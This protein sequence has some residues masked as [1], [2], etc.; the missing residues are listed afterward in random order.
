MTFDCWKAQY[1]RLL[2]VLVLAGLSVARATPEE[3]KGPLKVPLDVAVDRFDVAD[4][5][6][7]DG[8]S[9]LSLKRIDGL[10]LGFEE[11]L[12]NDV[13]QDPRATNPH[14]SLH[15][16]GQTVR[17]IL[18]SLCKI[19]PRYEWSQDGLTINVYP[20]TTTEDRL[21]L[22]NLSIDRLSVTSVSD[23]Y[24]AL[25]PLA[26]LFPDQQIGYAGTG[27]YSGYAEPWTT[28]FERLTVRQFI[29]RILEHVGPRTTWVWQG[30]KNERMF[31]FLKDGFN[32]MRPAERK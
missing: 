16:R 3:G 23:A 21:Y 11:V 4:A 13:R 31:A 2:G 28:V 17:E 14:F 10:H 20:R 29:N 27:G 18:D 19:D 32:S 25:T 1:A 30:G 5:I 6:M 9:E 22:L 26:K 7:R 15:L 12:R 8:V 24:Q